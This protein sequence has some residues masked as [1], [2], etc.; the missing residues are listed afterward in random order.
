SWACPTSMSGSSTVACTCATA[1]AARCA[2]TTASAPAARWRASNSKG[3]SEV[4]S[5]VMSCVAAI[6][7]SVLMA[8]P[9][10]SLA[11][12]PGI[13]AGAFVALSYHE[14][15]GDGPREAAPGAG[16]YGVEASYLIAQFAWLRENGYRPVSLAEIAEARAGGKPLPP[17]AVLL[18]FDDGYA[19]FYERVYPVLQL[20]SYPAVIALVG[21][22]MDVPAGGQVDYD[23]KPMP[24]EAFLSWGQVREMVGS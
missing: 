13:P 3:G 5:R 11:R 18:S 22:W 24:R 23:G 4:R 2:P 1:S 21:K 9:L 8:L 10:P 15:P 14:V 20:F 7:S 12:A 19:D 6:L 16:R 17:R